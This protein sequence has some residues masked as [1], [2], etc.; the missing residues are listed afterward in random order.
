MR[1]PL[2]LVPLGLACLLSFGNAFA[3][4]LDGTISKCKTANGKKGHRECVNGKFTPCL[5]DDEPPPPPAK[6]TAFPKYYIL[7][8]VYAPPGKAGGGSASV[9]E[10]KDGSTTGTITSANKSFKTEVKVSVEASAFGGSAGVNFGGSKKSSDASKLEISKSTTTT[11]KDPGGSVDGIDHNRDLIYLLLNP[12]VDITVQ[13]NNAGWTMGVTGPSAMIQFVHVGWLKDS[14]T[15]PKG[16][17][18][19]LA[20]RGLNAAD[21]KEIL[22][23]DPFADGS[24]T[25][26]PNRYLPAATTF[27]YEP[28]FAQGESGPTLTWSQDNKSVATS[29]KGTEHSY[30][31]GVTAG[32]G[33]N[34]G[35]VKTKMNVALGWTWTNSSERST[36]EG[37]TQTATVTVGSPSFGYTGSSLMEVYYD[38]LFKSYMFAPVSTSES[39]AEGR[40]KFKTKGAAV[41]KEVLLHAGGRT[42][43]TFTDRT[44]QYRFAGQAVKQAK[45]KK[46]EVQ[47]RGHARKPLVTKTLEIVL[48]D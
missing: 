8:V 15:M 24:T 46:M 14:A 41:G 28:P 48:P 16:V 43:R 18:D 21:F 13:G 22:K 37:S 5:A 1:S 10:Y 26:D 2:M 32:A 9:V 35:V 39:V 47:V 23:V 11:I 19:L 34:V 44:G 38:S 7:T 31:I 33:F 42:Y 4:C 45:G 29:T 12:K 36:S 25:I 30:T 27:P 6:G 17:A 3:E 20:S 40:V